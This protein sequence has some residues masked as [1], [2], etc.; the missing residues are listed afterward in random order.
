MKIHF[1][2][3]GGIGISALARYYLEKG[4]K[5]SGSDLT[6]SEIT[7]ALRKSGA[8]IYIGQH[9]V[10]HVP[11]AVDLVIYSLAV[12]KDNPELKAAK[13]LNSNIQIKSY[14]EALGG[15]TKKYFT[16]AVSG[17]HGKGTTTA[18]LALILIKAG[19]DPTVIIGTKLKE[20]ENT[21]FR[22]GE[23]AKY[24][25][26]DTKY[27]ILLIEADEHFASFLNY[28]PKLIVLTNIEREHLDYYKNLGNILKTFK[29]YIFHLPKNGALVINGD[30]KNISKIK[31]QISKSQFKIQNYFLSQIEAKKLRKILKVP[32]E[33]NVYNALAALSTA[34]ALK[35]P[36]RISFKALS[37]YKGVWRRFEITKILHP[38]PYTLVSD[39]AHHPTEI[40]ATVKAAREKWPHKEIWLVFQ[41]HQY[42]R[43]FYLFKDFVKV[44][45]EALIEKWIDKLIITD[46]Y[47]V[48]GREEKKI[49]K[50]VNSRKLVNTVNK[51][52]IHK[53]QVVACQLCK[54]KYI[55]D[56]EKVKGYLKENLRGGEVVI[57]MGAGN[58]Y[59][60]I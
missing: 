50:K 40:K 10:K 60:L 49:R 44:F 30:D 25:I 55:S 2:G 19:L 34:R 42:Q 9:K 21:N 16:I 24:Q 23:K 46:I 8:K 28:W 27:Q 53:K 12:Q 14:P 48:A 37:E 32:G 29:K 33:H 58:I 3:I 35:I 31:S 17:T 4:H 1:I 59:R 22:L 13:K 41:P 39:Y 51:Q 18:M 43:T 26:R 54:A 57:I 5:I 36:D 6:P 20:F 15:L 47:D 56:I 52:L 38:K 11:K 7:N 45:K